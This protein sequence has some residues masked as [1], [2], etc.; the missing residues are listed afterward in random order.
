MPLLCSTLDIYT[1]IPY[2]QSKTIS[3]FYVIYIIAFVLFDFQFAYLFA[4]I[5]RMTS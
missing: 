3:D 5:S 1:R 2:H 4:N